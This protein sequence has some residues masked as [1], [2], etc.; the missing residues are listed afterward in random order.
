MD[1]NQ[2]QNLVDKSPDQL[3]QAS[4]PPAFPQ[5]PTTHIKFCEKVLTIYDR[6][7]ETDFTDYIKEESWLINIADGMLFNG[8]NRTANLLKAC[9]VP[10]AGQAINLGTQ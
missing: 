5:T 6:P 10:T 9:S 4:Y 3:S 2:N 7:K 8:R 1:D